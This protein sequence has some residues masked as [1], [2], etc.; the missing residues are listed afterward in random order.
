MRKEK[1]KKSNKTNSSTF[2]QEKEYIKSQIDVAKHLLNIVRK[3]LENVEN[4]VN[5][6]E[7]NSGESEWDLIF[8]LDQADYNIGEVEDWLASFWRNLT[9][10]LKKSKSESK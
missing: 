4:V 1:P 6:I 10:R 5:L 7:D 2:D 9:V 8:D 3:C